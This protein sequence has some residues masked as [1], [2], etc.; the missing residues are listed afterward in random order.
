LSEEI[1]EL[2]AEREK[3][4][5]FK[6]TSALAP[7]RKSDGLRKDQKH[8]KV[9]KT[10]NPLRADTLFFQDEEKNI[11]NEQYQKFKQMI[12]SRKGELNPADELL[13][14]ELCIVIIRCYRKTRLESKFN[15]FMDRAAPQDPIAQTMNLLKS[16][17]LLSSKGTEV[18]NAKEILAK[19]LSKESEQLDG[20][21]S[22]EP[23]FEEWQAQQNAE[24]E[25]KLVQYTP[26]DTD[27]YAD[28]FDNINN[29]Q[30]EDSELA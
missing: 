15:R 21:A 30:E 10:K 23:T 28:E 4:L 18:G 6:E 7:R 12:L 22:H 26:T 13:L 27:G 20:A 29:S 9:K 17:G 11:Y 1:D 16:L 14:N 8:R 25:V 19:V 24:V 5:L 2:S 3:Y